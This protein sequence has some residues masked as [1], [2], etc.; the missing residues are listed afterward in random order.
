MFSA[1][2]F[3]FVAACTDKNISTTTKNDKVIKTVKKPATKKATRKNTTKMKKSAAKK[4]RK[5]AV[6]HKHIIKHKKH[7]A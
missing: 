1:C 4:H 7:K 2:C 3:I 6:T 5:L